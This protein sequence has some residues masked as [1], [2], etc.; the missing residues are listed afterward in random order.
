MPG[1]GNTGLY[2][3]RGIDSNR[4]DA[5]WRRLLSEDRDRTAVAGIKFGINTNQ[6]TTTLSSFGIT[7]LGK[8]PD[9]TYTYNITTRGDGFGIPVAIAYE[10]DFNMSGIRVRTLSN[11]NY[12]VDVYSIG[13]QRPVVVTYEVCILFF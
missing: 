1:D 8:K 12:E 5:N 7:G 13:G 10:S 6:T 11:T 9:T 4:W 2:F 3:R